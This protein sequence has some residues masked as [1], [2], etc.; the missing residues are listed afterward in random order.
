MS[1]HRK[2]K[3]TPRTSAY[4]T[5]GV[6]GAAMLGVGVLLTTAP[7]APAPPTASPDVQ[8][9]SFDSLL[10]PAP[11][12]TTTEPWWLD[13]DGR[14]AVGASVNTTF[15]TVTINGISFPSLPII[16]FFIGDGADAQPNCTGDEC[17]GGNAGILFG[18]G[19]D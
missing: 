18:D 2:T 9:A 10:A 19:G 14:G 4:V 12:D 15:T 7:G 13:E 1:K 5:T 17:N 6:G 11:Q 8:L 3:R 16:G